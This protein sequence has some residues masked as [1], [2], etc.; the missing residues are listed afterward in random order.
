MGLNNV[1]NHQHA[2]PKGAETE[3]ALTVVE[4]REM[5][6]SQ[7]MRTLALVVIFTLASAFTA[8]VGI[9]FQIRYGWQAARTPLTVCIVVSAVMIYQLVMRRVVQRHQREVR[10]IPAM[11]L[12]TS[13]CVE[14]TAMSVLIVFIHGFAS[15]PIFALS[16]PPLAGYFLFII[17]STLYLDTRLSLFT[18]GLASIQY[19]AIVV[20]AFQTMGSDAQTDAIFFTPVLYI[21]KA[22][23]LMLGAL[24]AAF[25]ARELMRRQRA[26]MVALE[27]R[28]REQ[29]ANAMKSRFLA[30]MS[31]EIRTPLNSVIGYAQLLE[32]DPE[33]TD[34]QRKSVEAIRVGGRHLMAVVNDVLDLSK[35]EA[36]RE[37]IVRSRFDLGNMLQELTLVFAV[38]CAEKNLTWI[39]E[40]EAEDCE[41]FGD[42]VRL[43]QVLTNI[44]GNAV[45]FTDA[46]HV[47]LRVMPVGGT[48]VR[49]EVEDTGPGI[50]RD[51]HDEIFDPFA[52][53]SGDQSRAGTGL[54]L[55][56]AQRFVQLMGGR[57]EIESTPG[58]G[59]RFA[60]SLPLVASSKDLAKGESASP[61]KPGDLP[62]DLRRSLR[63]AAQ[64]HNI[65][66]LR[67]HI[68]ELETLG[69]AERIFAAELRELCGTYD[70]KAVL[71][72]LED[73]PDA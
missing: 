64:G 42:E 11:V 23:I 17:L 51:R 65:T 66:D 68:T 61:V 21:A 60:F 63:H 40:M 13:A 38:Q 20:Y 70:M 48:A 26:S 58:K 5:L 53:E 22:M 6:N 7:A 72:A 9:Y 27:E 3:D 67:R 73:S 41:I 31:H 55:A 29:H 14:I 34:G 37:A 46:G 49:F 25:V 12:Y 28:N 57:I 47:A 32:A 56:I 71:T 54:G 36:G 24:G 4:T 2:D 30:D 8:A 62:E 16:A 59:S 19:L 45:K 18:G 39:F 33:I 10:A 35:I 44:L 69:E 43:R 1:R 52:Q 50:P 15:N